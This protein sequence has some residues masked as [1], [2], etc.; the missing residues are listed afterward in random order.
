MGL[1]AI[2][3]AWWILLGVWFWALGGGGA[4]WWADAAVTI[5][6]VGVLPGVAAVAAKA[7]RGAP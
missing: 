7:R 4:P 5:G 3:V 6:W 1:L 2:L